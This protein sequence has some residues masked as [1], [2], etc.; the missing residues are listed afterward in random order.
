MKILCRLFGHKF[1]IPSKPD[2]VSEM[3]EI[4][5]TI[6]C[7]RCLC[8]KFIGTGVFNKKIVADKVRICLDNILSLVFKNSIHTDELVEDEVKIIKKILRKIVG[9]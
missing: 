4:G 6:Y 9:I 2:S 3:G 8:S 5:I 1:I 7:D